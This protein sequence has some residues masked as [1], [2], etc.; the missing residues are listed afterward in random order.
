M[1]CPTRPTDVVEQG[2]SCEYADQ[3]TYVHNVGKHKR[4]KYPLTHQYFDFF[5]DAEKNMSPY[6]D[7]C[8]N[9]LYAKGVFRGIKKLHIFSDGAGK[10]FK[11]RFTLRI[12]RDLSRKLGIP[13]IYWFWA[14]YHGKG[15]CDGH[16]AV[17]KCTQGFR[18]R[19]ANGS[20]R[21]CGL[22]QYRSQEHLR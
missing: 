14:S 21:L 18:G 15:R 22:A 13:I 8:F 6:V 12:V 9:R 7:H 20:T 11:N 5:S 10:H 19:R 2:V 16:F 1:P 4:K 17:G 3:G